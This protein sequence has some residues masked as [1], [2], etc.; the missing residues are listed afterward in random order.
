MFDEPWR[1]AL[2]ATWEQIEAWYDE[3]DAVHLLRAGAT[4]HDLH[5]VESRLRVSLP[6]VLRASL[7]RHNGSL[8]EGWPGGTLLSCGAIVGATELWRKIADH[9][10]GVR[11]DYASPDAELGM[12][13]PGWWH[14]GWV[15]IDED[16][17]GNATAVDTAPGPL[18]APGQILEMDLVTGP[19]H[20][21]TDY[22][23]Y[24][25]EVAAALPDLRVVTR[26]GAHVL[27]EADVWDGGDLRVG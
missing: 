14:V 25:T 7:Q 15:A 2:E 16:P 18:G 8:M 17:F 21:S 12:L 22:V 1:P 19:I 5:K 24:L 27:E 9:G 3:N 23:T 4:E 26:D 10:D 20:S 11:R 13:Q 6:E